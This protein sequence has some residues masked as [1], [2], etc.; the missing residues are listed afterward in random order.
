MP[1]VNVYLPDDVAAAARAAGLNV[2][3]LTRQAIVDALARR[4]TDDWLDSL[5]SGESGV[6]RDEVLAALDAARDEL[7]D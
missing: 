3:A 1:R 4:A 2:S 7:G 5:A 6:T